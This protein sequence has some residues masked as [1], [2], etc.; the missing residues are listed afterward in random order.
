MLK[1]NLNSWT[2]NSSSPSSEKI[3]KMKEFSTKELWLRKKMQE[4]I[5]NKW[6]NLKL[7]KSFAWLSIMCWIAIW[8]MWQIDSNALQGNVLSVNSESA[9]YK[10]NLV[11][12]NQDENISLVGWLDQREEIW[13]EFEAILE[14]GK[15][16]QS[17]EWPFWTVKYLLLQTKNGMVAYTQQLTNA[18]ANAQNIKSLSAYFISESEKFKGTTEVTTV[19]AL[20]PKDLYLAF[21]AA[22]TKKDV[23]TAEIK[24]I[25]SWHSLK[26]NKTTWDSFL[27]LNIDASN[28]SWKTTKIIEVIKSYYWKNVYVNWI[29]LD[30]KKFKDN[31]NYVS[32]S[33]EL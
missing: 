18:N 6:F 8:S 27:M 4:T 32:V 3:A 26:V 20:P 1:T 12:L 23:S 24:K 10:A 15:S 21:E 7:A 28:I 19:T 9:S 13:N 31:E 11:Q 30:W 25:F 16:I 17:F 2:I 33:F 29:N 14:V 5:R 22:Y